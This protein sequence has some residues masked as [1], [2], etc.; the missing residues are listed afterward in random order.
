MSSRP[1][2]RL[3]GLLVVAAALVAIPGAASGQTTE[4]PPGTTDP[5]YCIP[6]VP[7]AAKR[8][9]NS[10]A[11]ATKRSTATKLAAGNPLNFPVYAAG[12]GRVTVTIYGR[13]P[14]A[15][16]RASAA[17]T[18]VYGTYTR[19][20]SKAGTFKAKLVLSK[21]GRRN[22]DLLIKQARAKGQKYVTLRIASNFRSTDGTRAT[23]TTTTKIRVGGS[24]K[25][26]F[27]G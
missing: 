1:R 21:S 9:A 3:I 16:R 4:C 23:T 15:A 27:T 13:K 18:I 7:V 5:T 22:L 11:A 12:P 24:N 2:F 20:Y 19:K 25:P 8:N 10:L 26:I 17:K 14:A 6:K